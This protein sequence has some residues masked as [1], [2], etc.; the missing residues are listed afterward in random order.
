[1]EGILIRSNHDGL[2]THWRIKRAELEEYWIVSTTLVW[3]RWPPWANQRNQY[4]SFSLLHL[5]KLDEMYARLDPPSSSTVRWDSVPWKCAQCSVQQISRHALVHTCGFDWFGWT[6][7]HPIRVDCLLVGFSPLNRCLLSKFFCLQ[8]LMGNFHPS[9]RGL[10]VRYFVL[11]NIVLQDPVCGQMAQ[12]W[13]QCTAHFKLYYG[14]LPFV[15]SYLHTW[16]SGLLRWL[17]CYQFF[18]S[19]WLKA[20]GLICPGD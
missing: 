9:V 6:D 5:S 3:I 13:N 12:S 18:F 17:E 7:D 16:F 8:G 1:M 14:D 4:V 2:N 15:I 11:S 20:L 19:A 10:Y